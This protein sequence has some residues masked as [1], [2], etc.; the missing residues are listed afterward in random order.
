MRRVIMELQ[1]V[2]DDGVVG[3]IELEEM[4]QRSGQ[5]FVLCLDIVDF[6]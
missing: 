2:V 6:Y 3:V 5:L 1:V 4:F